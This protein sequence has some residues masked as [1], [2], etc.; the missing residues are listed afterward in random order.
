MKLTPRPSHRWCRVLSDPRPTPAKLRRV[1]LAEAGWEGGFSALMAPVPAH[2]ETRFL[3]AGND[4][5]LLLAVALLDS[6]ANLHRAQPGGPPDNLEVLFDL[7]HDR[8]GWVQYLLPPPVVP[9][10]VAARPFVPGQD[11]HLPG[12]P[13]AVQAFCHQ[14]YPEA[15]SSAFALPALRR[16]AWCDESFSLC[17]IIRLA[18]RWAFVWFRT[19]DLFA[20]GSA[21]GLNVVR[22]RS[23]LDEYSSWNYCGGNGTQDARDFGTLYRGAPPAA[24]AD[25]QADWADG[26]LTLSGRVDGGAAAGLAL[27]L[28]DPRGDTHPVP[29]TVEGKAW[30]ARFVLPADAAGRWRLRG[31]T[32]AGPLLPDYLALDLPAPARAAA[33]TLAVTYDSPMCIITNHYTPARMKAEMGTLAGMGI[34]RINWIEYGH[35][36]S[37][38]AYPHYD[39]GKFYARTCEHGDFLAQAVKAAHANGI[40]LI[41]DYKTFDL[42]FNDFPATRNGEGAV[43]EIEGGYAAVIPEIAA[44]QECTMQA[45]PDWRQP[46]GGV[47]ARL[48]FYSAR[49]LPAIPASGVRLLVSRDNK[50]FVPYTGPLKFRQGDGRRPHRR[51]TPAGNVPAPGAARNWYVELAG[52]ALDPAT[53][54][55]ALDLGVEGVE[56]HQRGFMIAEAW[57][58]AGRPVAFTVATD[59][60][61][62]KGLKFWKQWPGWSNR[63]DLML[64]ERRWPARRLG[65]VCRVAPNLPTMLEPADAGA[66]AIWLA[67]L[68]A[69]LEAGV[70]GIDLRT[71]CHHN[72]ITSYAQYAYAPAVRE[73]FR[74]AFGREPRADDLADA[75]RVR[76]LR[77]AAYTEFVRAARALTAARGCKLMVELESGIEVPPTLDCRMQLPLEWRVWLEEGL[78]D[79]LRMKWFT[80]QSRFVHEEVLPLARRR[81]VPVHIISRCLHTGLGLRTTELA[82]VTV[83]DACGAGFAGYTWYEQHNLMD[84][85]PLGLAMMKGPV[86]NYFAHARAALSRLAGG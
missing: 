83:T 72:C 11:R 9:A 74:A 21:I 27:E 44:H 52:L 62:D 15:H 28:L 77:G 40:E 36:P 78:V 14:P 57:D 43:R 38:W 47:P 1:L 37:F 30:R 86:S 23:Y 10:D 59:G 56:L 64:E 46:D 3:V 54:F 13:A 2:D 68:T 60:S 84:M 63:N 79:E 8:I 53:P 65:L 66:H 4:R 70:D 17:P 51:W 16:H 31:R 34:R 71:Y 80:A 75:E 81:H 67:R 50:R 41:A 19:A 48:R 42:G 55:L 49:P 5:E 32:A 24:L 22:A 69:M 61:P 39:W 26:A 73:R 29:A 25:V 6:A 35:W 58:L 76:R 20:H 82:E 33:F 45:H 12:A 85:N 7:R 18:C